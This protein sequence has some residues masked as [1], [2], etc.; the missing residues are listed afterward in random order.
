MRLITRYVI[1]ETLKVFVVALAALT[2]VM[3]I[4]GLVRE[5]QSQGLEPRHVLRIVPY[6]LPDSLRYT[7]PATALFAVTI[8]CGRMSGSNEVVALKS[9]GIN[10]WAVIGPIYALALALSFMTVWINDLAVSW[11]RTNVRR[12]IIESVEEIAYGLLRSQRS[13]QSPQFSI[14]VK[15]VDGRRL[16]NPIINI[17][18]GGKGKPPITLSASEAE[19]ESDTKEMLLMIVCRDGNINVEGRTR[20]RFEHERIPIPLESASPNGMDIVTPA[21]IPGSQLPIETAHAKEKIDKFIHYRAGRAVCDLL[22]GEFAFLD[23]SE[24]RLQADILDELWGNLAR[25]KTEPHRRWSNGFS[26]LFFVMIG[27]PLSI[28]WRNGEIL[29]SFFACFGPILVLYY[30]LLAL[31]VQQAKDGHLPPISVWIG[32]I[33]L[34]LL[35]SFLLRHVIRY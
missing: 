20:V 25:L 33:V 22:C 28:W 1:I 17:K 29:S 15:G 8:V 19:L 21:Y 31:G 10:P 13:F 32:N 34:G 5:A 35:G 7:I 30:P 18:G 12:V 6:I 27:A 16:I 2:L 14:I 9:L 26:C 3:V 11:G 23:N 24:T 4:F